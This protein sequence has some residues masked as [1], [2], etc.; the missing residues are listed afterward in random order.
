MASRV[1]SGR[2]EA[3]ARATV[4]SY[5]LCNV[6]EVIAALQR[7]GGAATAYSPASH[8]AIYPG[9]PPPTSCSLAPAPCR[10][11]R[12]AGLAQAAT[13]QG[14][15]VA[16]DVQAPKRA[17]ISG[18]PEG[19]C[20]PEKRVSARRAPACAELQPRDWDPERVCDF[21][22]RSGFR[23]PDLLR[24]F[25]GAGRRALPAAGRGGGLQ[26]PAAAR[27][28]CRVGAGDRWRFSL[29]PKTRRLRRHR[30]PGCV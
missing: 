6:R 22:S 29:G 21:L 19:L 1:V 30:L 23:D 3:R 24:R 12:A 9:S 15:E 2:R 16:E 14:R 4:V 8:D 10:E 18:L 20:T 13:M 28:L 17:R 5:S 26:S 7:E 25:R 11:V 27:G